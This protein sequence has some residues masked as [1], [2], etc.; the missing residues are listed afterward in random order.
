MM[1]EKNKGEPNTEGKPA[2]E[3]R[4]GGPDLVSLAGMALALGGVLGGLLLEGG[5]LA[6]ILQLTAALIVAGG[7][8]GAGLPCNPPAGVRGAGRT[9]VGAGHIAGPPSRAVIAGE[10]SGERRGP[11]RGEC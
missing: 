3:Q 1:G 10:G 4:S 7:R 11:E 6:D 8:T 2:P 9:G 5:K